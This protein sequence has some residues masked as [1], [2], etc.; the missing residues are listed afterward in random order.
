MDQCRTI[1]DLKRGRIN[2]SNDVGPSRF[3]GGKFQKKPLARTQGHRHQPY[4]LPQSQFR[5]AAPGFR[6]YG[7]PNQAHRPPSKCMC[8]KA[9]TTSECSR[10]GV[11]CF[12]WGE[13][14]HFARDCTQPKPEPVVN[15]VKA[16]WRESVRD[17]WSRSLQFQEP[18]SR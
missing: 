14:G 18:N 13:V 3:N 7:G 11:L 6:G 1:E 15:N 9:H 17:E 16:V 2:R 8:G 4:Q 12:Q 10:K 5:P